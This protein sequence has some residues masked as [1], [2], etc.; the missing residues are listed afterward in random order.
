MSSRDVIFSLNRLRTFLSRF[1]NLEILIDIDLK[2]VCC[3]INW[4]RYWK[5][6][7]RYSKSSQVCPS[8]SSKQFSLF[9]GWS[10]SWVNRWNEF[11][12]KSIWLMNLTQS[13]SNSKGQS[14][15]KFKNWSTGTKT[16]RLIFSRLSN[17]GIISKIWIKG[18][19]SIG[20][21]R[22]RISEKNFK[23]CKG[24]SWARNSGQ[25]TMHLSQPQKQFSPALVTELEIWQ[26]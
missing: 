2:V 11:P 23:V 5:L 1:R 12:L 14:W 17:W 24:V 18:L 15:M 10:V 19:S 20:K 22:F 21:E 13:F 26:G 7:M 4:A 6:S 9:R 8:L 25:S 3:S 16:P